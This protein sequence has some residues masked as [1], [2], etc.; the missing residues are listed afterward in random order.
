MLIAAALS[1][2]LLAPAD[3]EDDSVAARLRALEAQVQALQKRVDVLEARPRVP[4]SPSEVVQE[5]AFII[6]VG[7]SPTLGSGSVDLVVFTDF[8]CPFC[9]RVHP[10]LLEMI[11]AQQLKAGCGSCIKIIH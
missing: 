6:P 8:Q 4:P 9:S 7:S 5:K 1:L 2:L 11:N 10:T 3:N